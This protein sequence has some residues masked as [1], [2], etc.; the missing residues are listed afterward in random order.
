MIETAICPSFKHQARL[1]C[2]C[3]SSLG[4]K[5]LDQLGLNRLTSL[6]S[7]AKMS[8]YKNNF[9]SSIHPFY[10]AVVP[11]P[12]NQCP[13]TATAKLTPEKPPPLTNNHLIPHTFPPAHLK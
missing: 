4:H 10:P 5:C 12:C 9:F 3:L 11:R 2:Y 8:S 13:P 1:L 6:A 7:L